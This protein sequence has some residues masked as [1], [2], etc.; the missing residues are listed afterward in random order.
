MAYVLLDDSFCDHRKVRRAGNEAC[1]VFVRSISYS[2]R[3]LTDGFV[4]REWLAER[5]GRSTK[6]LS[7]LLVTSG[8]WEPQE[9]GWVIHDYLEWNRSRAEVL[10]G[11]GEISEKR[12]AAG[13]KGAAVTNKKRWGDKMVSK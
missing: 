10:A 8:L 4:D 6:R 3:D 5:A 9:D 7:G 1:G 12:A 2:A 11:R 13:R